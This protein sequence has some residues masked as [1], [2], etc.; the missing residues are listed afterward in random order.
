MHLGNNISQSIVGQSVNVRKKLLRQISY[1]LWC[2]VID[3]GTS[4]DIRHTSGEISFIN[5]EFWRK[6][7]SI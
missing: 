4:I 6:N 5:Y 2:F 7:R 1:R 3:K